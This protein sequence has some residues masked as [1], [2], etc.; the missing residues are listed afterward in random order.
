V[1]F[2][3]SSDFG[4][5]FIWGVSS[6]A[7]Q[8]EGH[9]EYD[10]KGASIWDTFAGIKGN[11]IDQHT[12]A[13]ASLFIEHFRR[14][15]QLLAHLGIKNF[16][17]SISWPRIF[18]DGKGNPNAKGILFYQELVNQLLE[19]GI[20]PWVTLYHWDLPQALEDEGGWK[21]RATYQHFCN[22]VA[23]CVNMLGDRVKNWM[24]LNEPMVF[25]G[26]GYFLGIHAPGRRGLSTFLPA[27]HHIALAQ[28]EGA[29]AARAEDHTANIGTTHSYTYFRAKNSQ[30][31]HMD[32]AQ[33][34][35][36]FINKLYPNLITGMGYPIDQLP[37]LR[38]V[39]K[40]IHQR[41]EINL[42]FP[43]DFWGIQ[44]YTRHLV[45]HNFWIPYLKA[46]LLDPRKRGKVTATGWEVYPDCMTK[47]IDSMNSIPGA[48]PLY[49]TENG[50]ALHDHPSN[51]KVCDNE[52]I[53]YLKDHLFKLLIAKKRG[54]YVKGYFVWSATDNFEWAHGY[55]PRFGLIYIDFLSGERILKDSAHWFSDFIRT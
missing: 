33:R 24:I 19:N 28:S 44:V 14:D 38:G 43:F 37:F 18:P 42:S 12:P 22:Y 53:Q 45:R 5:D 26:A 32:A 51:G 1:P 21:N 10:G 34:A 40:H 52:R 23:F 30:S 4:P 49:I 35:D 55:H 36:L 48:P 27:M 16:R 41:D 13:K 11:I 54:A 50:M 25:A 3:K 31:K 47:A 20:T 46:S 8:T 6:S 17:F 29:R 2:I 9:S 15:I 39:E 7:P